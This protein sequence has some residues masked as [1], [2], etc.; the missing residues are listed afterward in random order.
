MNKPSFPLGAWVG[1]LS[2]LAFPLYSPAQADDSDPVLRALDCVGQVSA[3]RDETDE[4][5]RLRID[6]HVDDGDRI[7]TG[8]KSEAVLRLKNRVYLHLAANT[9]LSI[10]RLRYEEGR[11]LTFRV[12]LLAGKL[13]A[14]MDQ[15]P[16]YPFE[17]YAEDVL[18]RAHGSLVE[19]VNLG[20]KVK[21]YS[22]L[23][24]FVTNCKGHTAI[25]K[26]GQVVV[27]EKGKFKDKSS[28][29]LKDEVDMTEWREHLHDI[30]TGHPHGRP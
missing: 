13:V 14:Q 26:K 6:Q 2:I 23:G 19:V 4:T 1:V 12:T 22:H 17:I 30:R 11:G 24:A 29:S 21:V 5:S 3:Y 8:P 9:R 16:N 25:A 28:I 7:T 15:T 27:Y 10:S 20:D 18:C